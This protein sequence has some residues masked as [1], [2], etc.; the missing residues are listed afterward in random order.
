[1]LN[2][3]LSYGEFLPIWNE[4]FFLTP[5][6]RAVHSLARSL[7]ANYKL[8]VLSNINSLHFDYVKEK[9]PVFDAFHRVFTSFEFGMIKPHPLIYGKALAELGVTPEETFYTDDRQELI[10]EAAKLGI[11]S[12]VYKTPEKLKEDLA[13]CGI[14]TK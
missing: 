6:N 7:S 2:L 13:S 12:F 4:I 1:M 14:D 8:A 9:F 10:V 11:K 5:Q 3:R